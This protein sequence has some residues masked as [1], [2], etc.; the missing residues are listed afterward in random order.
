MEISKLFEYLYEWLWISNLKIYHKI[1][2]S[3]VSNGDIIEKNI[4]ATGYIMFR[5][6]PWL[7]VFC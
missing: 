1:N 7:K 3:I 4:D 5:K 2:I 6:W